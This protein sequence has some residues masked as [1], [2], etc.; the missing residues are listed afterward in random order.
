ML[1]ALNVIH[2]IHLMPVMRYEITGSRTVLKFCSKVQFPL[3]PHR[4]RRMQCKHSLVRK[5]ILT[6]GS[7]KVYPLKVYSYKSLKES[8]YAMMCHPGMLAQCEEWRSRKIPTN[9]MFDVYDGKV[10]SEFMAY[11]EKPFFSRK[12]QFGINAK[13]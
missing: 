13:C 8:L 4:S 3:H 10:W 12:V 5:V 7:E 11:K 1:Y 6:N 2:F 9:C